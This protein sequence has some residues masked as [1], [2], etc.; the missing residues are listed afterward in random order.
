MV[1]GYH[2]GMAAA[3]TLDKK[4][5]EIISFNPA[6]GVEIGRAM[7]TL[8]DE[9]A[10]VVASS[11]NAFHLWKTTS[12]KERRELIMNARQV[13]LDQLDEIAHLISAESGKPVAE[14]ISMEIA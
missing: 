1:F 6:T 14:A 3:S 12:F 10:V 11:R 9:V 8:G 2:H 13:I 4:S 7:Q 5:D